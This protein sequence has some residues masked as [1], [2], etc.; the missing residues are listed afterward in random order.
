MWTA[1]V[2]RAKDGPSHR[3]AA[4]GPLVR[5]MLNRSAVLLQARQ[6]RWRWPWALL[7]TVLAFLGI[8]IAMGVVAAALHYEGSTLLDPKRPSSFLA[9][10]L[11]VLPLIVVPCLLMR[12]VHGVSWRRLISP[13][14]H[15]DWSIFLRAA[16]AF[17]AV[18]AI[19]GGIDYAL[20]PGSYRLVGR[21][22]EFL[23][24]LMLGLVVILAQTLAEEVLFR[25]YLLRIWGA[26][27]PYGV[28]TTAVVMCVFISLHLANPDMKADIWFNLA[29]FAINQLLWC[30]VWF[31]TQSIA[32][33]TGLHWA[34]NVM[35]FLVIA[36]LPGWAPTMAI[37]TYSDA[38]LLK[39]GSH[40]L[41]PYCWAISLIAL[42]LLLWLLV[43]ARSPF[44]LPVAC[45]NHARGASRPA[46]TTT[47]VPVTGSRN[48]G[49]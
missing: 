8:A 31:R 35:C 2:T 29:I 3:A 33:T 23:P 21:S 4:W 12:Y 9:L 36:P 37:A 41:D 22:A 20:N 6:G 38:V 19:V 39:G 14:G 17:F 18:S 49:G 10:V 48:L 1:M 46:D 25:G 5:A 34:N 27:L 43:W 11:V 24:W 32:A 13:S 15:F 16:G 40:L 47:S 28:P 30:Y 44:Y 45:E 7:S 26:V 42:G